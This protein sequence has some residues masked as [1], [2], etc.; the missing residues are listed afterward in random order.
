MNTSS[1]SNY[2]NNG[3]TNRESISSET[4]KDDNI[5]TSTGRLSIDLTSNSINNDLNNNP[6]TEQ[7]ALLE[8][9]NLNNR[10]KFTFTF[11]KNFKPRPKEVPTHTMT[12]CQKKNYLNFNNYFFP[13]GT[14]ITFIKNRRRV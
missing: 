6:V 7:K 3:E 5:I 11:N 9:R 1:T 4:V 8:I 2:I 10:K 12:V 14:R 13:L